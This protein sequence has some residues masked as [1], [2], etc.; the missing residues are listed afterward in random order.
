M[1]IDSSFKSIE[2]SGQNRS[3]AILV[4]NNGK[5]WAIP[6]HGAKNVDLGK[7]FDYFGAKDDIC[8]SQLNRPAS[9]KMISGQFTVI[10]KGRLGSDREWDRTD[11]SVK[12]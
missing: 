6:R 4:D 1:G 10:N 8:G 7:Y 5:A 11:K 2:I 3:I 9:G 12:L